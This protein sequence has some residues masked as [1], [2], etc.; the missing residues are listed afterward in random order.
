MRSTGLRINPDSM[1]SG[2]HRTAAAVIAALAAIAAIATTATTATTIGATSAA[3]VAGI[4]DRI[5]RVLGLPTGSGISGS[6]SL[7]GFTSIRHPVRMTTLVAAGVGLVVVMLAVMLLIGTLMR[8]QAVLEFDGSHAHQQ[9]R[10]NT[11]VTEVRLAAD[12]LQ[13]ERGDCSAGPAA[14]RAACLSAAAQTSQTALAVA[15]DRYAL[16]PSRTSQVGVPAA[17]DPAG[18]G[19]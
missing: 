2:H 9:R 14:K 18:T 4:R 5:R 8:N 1:H 6:P 16:H 10:I 12:V 17:S 11:F 13:D 7:T 19:R 15:R 3:T